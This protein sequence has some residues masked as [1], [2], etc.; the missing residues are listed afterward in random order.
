[1]TPRHDGTARACTFAPTASGGHARYVWELLNAL[2]REDHRG[3]RHELVTSEDLDPELR[4]DLYAVHPILPPLQHRSSFPHRLAWVASRL[5]HYLRRERAFLQ[6]LASR[7]DIDLVH[8]QEWTPWLAPSLVRR[9]RAMG[10]RVVFTVHNIV[11]HKYPRYVPRTMVNHWIRNACRRCDGLFVHSAALAEQLSRRLGAGHPPIH[12]TPHGVWTLAPAAGAPAATASTG[13]TAGEAP[14]PRSLAERLRTKRLLFFGSIRRN[15]GLDLLLRAAASLPDYSITIAGE[16]L[17]AAYHENEVLP[18]VRELQ[19]AGR[20]IDLRDRFIP[21][22]DLPA[23]FAAHSAI[24]LPY[25]SGF[26][27]QSG[28]VFMALAHELPVISTEAGGLA[29]LMRDF[30]IGRTFRPATAEALAKAV[31]QLHEEV[32]P[33]ALLREIR[34]AR[35]KYSWSS[36][37]SATLLGYRAAM[38]PVRE[39]HDCEVGTTPAC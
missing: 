4:C 9:I 25:T 14:P 5:A 2:A 12:V 6:W 1:M 13:S 27:A 32:D 3:W 7:P 29:E 31:R 16:P 30:P 24:L 38:E 37:A 28:V 36:A 39:S 8:L 23:L 34:A 10:K 18:L 15:K 33:E 19:R 11:P 35:N 26:V 21:E 22:Q 17:D 20:Q